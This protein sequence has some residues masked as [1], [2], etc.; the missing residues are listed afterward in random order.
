MQKWGFKT[1]KLYKLFNWQNP[2]V[3]E[4]QEFPQINYLHKAFVEKWSSSSP[5]SAAA[6]KLILQY[7]AHTC[8][9]NVCCVW[10]TIALVYGNIQ[11]TTVIVDYIQLW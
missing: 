9:A 7:C 1:L 11:V 8:R 4:S 6:L 2:N 3:C 10:F 5:W